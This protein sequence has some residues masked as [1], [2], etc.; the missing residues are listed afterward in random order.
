MLLFRLFLT[1]V[2]TNGKLISIFLQLFCAVDS[3]S[4]LYSVVKHDNFLNM[5]ISQGSVGTHLRCG[6]MLNND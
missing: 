5:E 2:A 4:F 6:E 3:C 1:S